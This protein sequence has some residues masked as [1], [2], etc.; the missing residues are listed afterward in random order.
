MVVVVGL[1]DTIVL[2]T[3]AMNHHVQV[4]PDALG[5]KRHALVSAIKPPANHTLDV[6]G[7]IIRKIVRR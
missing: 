3:T 6:V 2:F 1:P 7:P 5:S 4:K